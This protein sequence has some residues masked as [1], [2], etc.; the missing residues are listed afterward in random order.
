[1]AGRAAYILARDG[2]DNIIGRR[3]Q[4]LCDD[5]ELVDVVLSGEERLALEH[6]GKD[7]ARTPDIH[8]NVVLLP[9]EHDLGG[10]VVP[11]R[12]VARHLRVLDARETKVADLQVAVLVDQDVTWLQVSVN[13]AGRVDVFQTPHDLVEEV[14]DELLLQ[15]SRGEKPV[16]I[17][18]QQLRDEVA[19]A[20]SQ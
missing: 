18:S 14:L 17:G 20:K 5:G 4:E 19:E 6:L 11:C 12:H 7:T 9:C 13:N 16:Q 1:M 15:G 2:V 3:S 8:L 10:A